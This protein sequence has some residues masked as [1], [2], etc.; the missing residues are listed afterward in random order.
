MPANSGAISGTVAH[1]HELSGATGGY[2]AEGLTGITGGIL[3]EVL[4]N[5][6]TD[7]PIWAAVPS[8]AAGA[9]ADEGSVVEAD[10]AG[11]SEL[12]LSVTDQDVYNV[13]Y[14]ISDVDSGTA[15]L[16][17]R[18]NGVT[19]GSYETMPVSFND[20]ASFS[21]PA[22]QSRYGWLMSN[23]YTGGRGHSGSA[24]VYKPNPNFTSNAR[25]RANASGTDFTFGNPHEPVGNALWQGTNDGAG[26]ITSPITDISIF[27]MTST[28]SAPTQ[29]IIGSMRVN[30]LSYS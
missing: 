26:A 3:N 18:I 30:S 16:C 10:A 7:I 24:Y 17:M 6:G 1:K 4:T 21:T 5:D 23:C 8:P 25:V 27:M 15:T 11:I 19:A 2:L 20:G 14:S 29:N 9:W 13:I 12:S 22:T 28:S